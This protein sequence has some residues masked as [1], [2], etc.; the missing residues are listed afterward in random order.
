[1]F[2][3]ALILGVLEG[4]TE[5]LP[6]S[7]TAHLILAGELLGFRGGFAKL[8]EV[9]IQLGAIL[10]VVW[11]F[12]GRI[13]KAAGS[14][15]K[16]PKSQ[17]LA[18]NLLLG[19]VPSGVVGLV[20]HRWIK[21]YLFSPLWVC[22]ALVLGGVAI[23]AFEASPLARRGGISDLEAL[24]PSQALCIGL[25][26][27]LAL[28]PGVSRAAATI[29]GGMAVGLSRGAALEFSFLL[30]I[31]TMAAA[32][33]FDLLMNAS[34]VG[35]KEAASLGLGFLAAFASALVAASALVSYVKSHSFRPF[36]YY[37]IFLGGV[38]L[39]MGLRS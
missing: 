29:L 27:T 14:I 25:C 19:F 31:P 26:Q 16:D 21:A 3:D 35:V 7:S 37:R 24:K 12:R 11:L 28:I 30:A 32:C 5:F 39:L 22:S 1:V 17:L 33:L 8:F 13:L 23:L 18:V 4:L 38:I 15:R 10:S 6:I 9:F 2:K 34:G 36:G 20:A